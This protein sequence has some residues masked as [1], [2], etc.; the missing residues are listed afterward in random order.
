M[1][2]LF[3]PS[4]RRLAMIRQASPWVYADV[5]TVNVAEGSGFLGFIPTVQQVHLE[6]IAWPARSSE[7]E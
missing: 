2:G 5:Q 3:R 4:R 6:S 1:F 7:G